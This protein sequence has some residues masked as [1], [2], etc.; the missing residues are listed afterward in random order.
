MG[1]CSALYLD[2]NSTSDRGKLLH[3]SLRSFYVWQN[4][5]RLSSDESYGRLI[6]HRACCKLC[7]LLHSTVRKASQLSL[8]PIGVR[9]NHCAHTN[10]EH[11]FWIWIGNEEC[12][13]SRSF[14]C[15]SGFSHDYASCCIAID[16]ESGFVVSII[17]VPNL[18]LSAA[19]ASVLSVPLTA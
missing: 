7:D 5:V 9:P 18:F 17:G 14:A 1:P 19:V 2:T 13:Q 6:Y 8:V 11:L 12:N 15:F 3:S 4:V 16:P 10:L